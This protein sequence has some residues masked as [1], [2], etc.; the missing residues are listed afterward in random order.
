MGNHRSR[1]APARTFRVLGSGTR[2]RL[3][4]QREAH[5][6]RLRLEQIRNEH[7]LVLTQLA[8]TQY[9]LRTSLREMKYEEEQRKSRENVGQR[10]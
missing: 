8:I 9:E 3:T 7:Q 1:I 5:Q 10:E 4:S 6:L 2:A